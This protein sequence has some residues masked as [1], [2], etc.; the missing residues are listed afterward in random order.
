MPARTLHLSSILQAFSTFLALRQVDDHDA[1][2]AVVALMSV[3]ERKNNLSDWSL[4]EITKTLQ[5]KKPKNSNFSPAETLVMQFVEHFPPFQASTVLHKYLFALQESGCSSAT[6]RNYRSDISQ[7]FAFH[8][9]TE[10]QQLMT[11]PKVLEFLIDQRHKNLKLSSIRR[12]LSSITQFAQWLESNDP[13]IHLSK[14]LEELQ[15]NLEKILEKQVSRQKPETTRQAV[16]RRNVHWNMPLKQHS[17][18][19]KRPIKQPGSPRSHQDY[20]ARLE[21]GWRNIGETVKKKSV[22]KILPY[23]NLASILLF[24]LGGSYFAYAQFFRDAP[25]SQAFPETPVR[26]SRVLSF[27]G[28]LTDT[29]QNPVVTATDFRFK[30]FDA[31]TGGTELWDSGTCSVDPDQDGIFAT[32]LGDPSTGCGAEIGSDVFTE[33]SNIWLEV[34]VEAETLTPRQQIRTV[35][36]ALNSETVQGI[37]VSATGSATANTLLI[38]DEGGEVVLGEVSPKIRSTNGT[39]TIDAQSL[40]LKTSTGSNGDI[41]LSPDGTGRTIVNSNLNTTGY[42]TA[43]GATLSATYAGGTALVVRGGPSGTANIQ[44]WQNAAGAALSVIN[45]AGNLGVGTTNPTAGALHVVGQCVT[46]DTKLRRKRKKKRNKQKLSKNDPPCKK[47]G[48]AA[49][50]DTCEYY[51]LVRIDQIQP[52]DV[53]QTLD[54]KTGAFVDSP[55]RGLLDMGVQQVFEI[56]TSHGKKIKTTAKHPYLTKKPNKQPQE[57]HIITTTL[58]VDQSIRIEQTAGDTYLAI[59]N[60]EVSFAVKLPQAAKQI[61]L[62]LHAQKRTSKFGFQIFA[63]LILFALAASRFKTSKLRIDNEYPGYENEI[64]AIIGQQYPDLLVEFASIGKKSPAHYSAY[65]AYKSKRANYIASAGDLFLRAQGAQKKTEDYGESEGAVTHKDK[66]STI[67]SP[68]GQYSEVYQATDMLSTKWQKVAKLRPG[69]QIAT[70]DGFEHIVSIKTL[71]AQQTYDIEVE[72]THNFVG[73]DIVAHNTYITGNVGIGATPSSYKLDVAGELNLTDAIRVAGDAGTSGYL[74]TSS[75]GGANTWT[76]PASIAAG[77]VAW[78]N[79]TAPVANL[80]LAMSTYTTGFNWATGTSTNNLFSFTT[81]ASANGTGA[82]VNIQTGTSSTVSPLR[83]R[84]GATEAIFVKNDGNVGIGTT[85]PNGKLDVK[86]ATNQHFQISDLAGVTFLSI[87][88]DAN[89]ANTSFRIDA[90][91]TVFGAG[92]VGIGTTNPSSKLFVSGTIRNSDNVN[93]TGD[94]GLAILSG[95]RLGFNQSGT[96]SWTVKATAGN[97]DFNS[98][99]GSGYH[100]FNTGV[101]V[102]GNVGIGDA[103]PDTK[104]D[105]NVPAFSSQMTLNAATGVGLGVSAYDDGGYG[106]F[107]GVNSDGKSWIQGGRVS[108]GATAYDIS[109][110]AAGGN[111]GIGSTAPTTKLDVNGQVRVGT[112]SGTS[113]NQLCYDGSNVLTPCASS[114]SI[115]GTGTANYVARWT[116]ATNLS[117]GVL[118]DN[119][120]NVGIGYTNPAAKLDVNG[121]IFTYGGAVH[122]NSGAWG[123][124][125]T[126]ETTPNSRN[127]YVLQKHRGVSIS[128]HSYY[129]GVRIYNQEGGSPYGYNGTMV[130]AITDGNVGIG[131]ASPTQGKLVVQAGAGSPAYFE[132]SSDSQLTLKGTNDWAGATF[133]DSSNSNTIWYR[134]STS[135]FAIGGGGSIV[136]GK[137]LHI[138]GGVTIGSNYDATAMATNGLSVEGNIFGNG[139]ISTYDTTVSDNTVETGTLCLGNGTNC[140]SNW[141]ATGTGRSTFETNRSIGG[142]TGNTVA[143]GYFSNDG[144]GKNIRIYIKAHTSGTIDVLTFDINDHAYIGSGTGWLEIPITNGISYAGTRRLT[145]DVYRQNIWSASDPLYVRIRNA[146]G[147]GSGSVQVVV[148]HDDDS[149]FTELTAQSTTGTAF[150]ASSAPAGGAVTGTKGNVEWNFPVSNGSAWDTTGT[151][152][153]YIQNNGN[154]GIGTT[155]P[156]SKLDVDGLMINGSTNPSIS[157]GGTLR[158]KLEW[159]GATNSWGVYNSNDSGSNW[160]PN[161]FIEAGGNVGIGTTGPAAKLEVNGDALVSADNSFSPRYTTS[162][163]YRG[164]FQWQGLQLGNNGAN[165]IVAG[166]TNTGGSLN[167]VVNNTV[168]L[169]S[170]PAAHNGEVAL[171]I[172]S[173]GT[174]DFNNNALTDINWAGSDDGSGSGLDAD[175]L[176]GLDLHNTQSTQNSANQ[177][178]R[179]QA[180]GYTMLGWINT[181]SGDSGI[182]NDVTRIYV[183][184]DSYLRYLNKNDFKTLVG[185]TSKASYDRRDSTSDSNYWVGSMGWNGTGMNEVFHGG[186]GFIDTWSGTNFPPGTTHVQG[187]N[188]LHYTV[189]S[190]GSTGGNAYGIQVAGQYNQGGTIYTRGVSAGTFSSWYKLWSDGNDGAGSGLDADLLDGQHGSYYMTAATDNWVNTT[191]DTMTGTLTFSGVTNDITTAGGEHL[192]LMPGGNVGIGTTA[193][194]AKLDIAGT[195]S[196]NYPIYGK[197]DTGAKVFYNVA[198]YNYDAGNQTGYAIIQTNIP[199]DDHTMISV[200]V[201]VYGQYGNGSTNNCRITLS[202]YWSSEGNGGFQGLGHTNVCGTKYNVQVA[203]NTSTGKSAI[204]IGSVGTTW[205]YPKIFVPKMEAGYGIADSYADSWTISVSTDISGYSNND[206][207]PDTTVV[208]NASSVAYANITGIPT[209]TAWSGV[210]RGFVAEQLSWKN[211]GN[212][213]TIFDASQ[214]TSP[215]GT[216]VNNTNSAVAW[217]AT[218][219]TLMGW[220]GAST[221]GVRVDSSR[222]SDYSSSTNDI[223]VNTTG[224]TMSGNLTFNNYGLGVVGSYSSVRYQNVFSMGGSYIPSADGTS[225]SN[226]YGIAY[227]HTNVGGQ[228]KAGLSHQALFVEAG[229]TKTAIGTGIWTAGAITGLSSI[230]ASGNLSGNE[231][232]TNSWF[233]NYNRTGIYNETYGTHFYTDSGSYWNVS[234]NYGLKINSTTAFDSAVAGYLYHDGNGFGLL[235]SGGGWA[236]RTNPG[237]DTLY[238]PGNVGIGDTTPSQ[239][240]DVTGNI[241][242]SGHYY[243]NNTSPTIYLQ[244]T[245]HRSSMIHQ[246]SNIF[247]IL[248]GGGNNSTTW[249][250]TGG[251]WPLEIDMNDNQARFGGHLY[252][253]DIFP[254]RFT[255]CGA[256][257]YPTVG[258]NVGSTGR[259]HVNIYAYRVYSKNSAIGGFDLAEN[260]PYTGNL[261]VGDVVVAHPTKKETVVGSS[262]SYQETV[263]GIVSTKPGITLGTNWSDDDIEKYGDL[264]MKPIALAGRVPVKVTLEGGSIKTNDKITSSSTRKFGMKSTKAGHVIAVAM[265]DFAP[266]QTSCSAVDSVADIVWPE[267]EDGHNSDKPC[268]YTP[269]GKFFGKI[270][271]LVNASWY[272]PQVYLSSTGDVT[273]AGQTEDYTVAQADGDTIERITLLAEAVIGKLRAGLVTTQDL[274]VTNSA[275]IADLSITSLQVGT[276]SLQEYVE[277]IVQATLQNNNITPSETLVSP[278]AQIETLTAQTATVSG[279]T[280]TQ[281]LT[282]SG[283]TKLGSLLAE[284]A[285][286]AGTLTADKVETPTLIA[287]QIEATSARITALEAGM[288]Q[289]E[290]VRAQTAEIVDATISG[291]LYANN[292][293]GFEEKLATSLKEPTLLQTLIGQ[294]TPTPGTAGAIAAAELAGFQATPSAALQATLAELQL[295][296]GDVVLS[297][298]ALFVDQYFSVNG[299]GYIAESLGIGNKLFVGDG[300]EFSDGNIAYNPTGV[301]RPTLYIQP[302]GNGSLSL[303]AGLMILS[304]DGTIAING[305]LTV[306]GTVEADTL[307]SNLLQPADFGNPFQVQVAGISTESGQVK[308][309][310]FEIINELGTPV[311]TI[312]AQGKANFSGGIGVGND[313]Q[314]ATTSGEITTD[315]TSGKATILAGTNELIIRSTVLSEDSLIYVTPVGSTGNK[316]LYVK[317]QQA[318]QFVVGF[319]TATT[320]NVPFNW[321]VVN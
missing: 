130:M 264:P 88:N 221:Y 135:T 18:Q 278:V 3:L 11:K 87:A 145:V 167:F 194:A 119:G 147:A 100:K 284:S 313:T 160:Q 140:I 201:D 120:T 4:E 16:K 293:Y 172:S 103:S 238:M 2:T 97:L 79:I 261:E 254:R 302:T 209:R 243:P 42:F 106:M 169:S 58:E 281:S 157:D 304:D 80:S 219:P 125:T 282:V 190:Y 163:S 319:D 189:N 89:T 285:T 153:M 12:K 156:G 126:E 139:G 256:G 300:L 255:C 276:Q 218:Y 180:N 223:F 99:D 193:P 230:S 104:L 251:Y 21:A 146:N 35:A 231:V 6:I 298:A 41:N 308:E 61:L 241:R 46:G 203:R 24:V 45:A 316:V 234:S 175:L 62:E 155:A 184:N 166:N 199:Q 5:K 196:T 239:K 188:A 28:R 236:L 307:L 266:D 273:I 320:S 314:A 208:A 295:S 51:E 143:L 71:E 43:P 179:T 109:L 72:N 74:L 122:T 136:S 217:T 200:D 56:M 202:G 134:G 117:T 269:D 86:V 161:L 165:Y 312:S 77:S 158:K 20:R 233:R 168:D 94:A 275:T 227:T 75:A 25:T 192:A 34:I 310:R 291:T 237:S 129:G 235:H 204:I 268:F 132:T 131:S 290:S 115:T 263:M 141:G 38:L 118:Y 85:T 258:D 197:G 37:P 144:V 210:H 151:H 53:I 52:S 154:V 207:V 102:T 309:S 214:S 112:L 15:A 40:L 224:D 142:T 183:S 116:S 274:V 124:D 283:P 83:V 288:A 73:N 150:N 292:I 133:S 107:F 105:I 296:E 82:L 191:G 36:Y 123:V 220:N 216:S 311:A 101:L 22:A 8:T 253:R 162:D 305:D 47:C 187:F 95:D 60:D 14:E 177:V 49:T 174:F 317:S 185:L 248:R 240:L 306:A 226:M 242:S 270:M 13:E 78:S 246:N 245:D 181:T 205:S 198:N 27:Q 299:T 277:D 67:R 213:H 149:T 272:D 17:T 91:Q 250:Q 64:K 93:S 152:G 63:Q 92:N 178:L 297:S 287:G 257:G 206:T 111:V 170:D 30:L 137:K 1:E 31:N 211:Y 318:D 70:I 48:H 303:L 59:A 10:L 114:S 128:A 173:A 321:W 279:S 66:S 29:A 90:S 222:V 69:V 19:V 7:F 121:E 84:A 289:L 215:D 265:E 294:Q 81:D 76:D 26:P 262:S 98:G 50:C 232:Y 9:T 39:F 315:K 228:S 182:A 229:V 148:E 57:Q 225:L 96:R 171:N 65:G 195:T 113:T 212:N 247:Y 286:V 176:D 271:V 68:L 33:N 164:N 244:D 186:S 55:V 108:G 110:Q 267:D 44:E 127:A 23:I 280:T 54:E 138:D 301:E 249:A 260:M 252:A 159:L 32:G 259:Y